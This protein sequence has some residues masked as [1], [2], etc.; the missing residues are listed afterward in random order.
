M[1]QMCLQGIPAILNILTNQFKC[2]NVQDFTTIPDIIP[3]KSNALKAD[4]AFPSALTPSKL[5]S[6]NAGVLKK[7]IS[8]TKPCSSEEHCKD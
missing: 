8:G 7:C 1:S 2:F 4:T 5:I 3:I 6:E